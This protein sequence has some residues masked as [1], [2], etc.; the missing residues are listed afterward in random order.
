MS[1]Y[2]K[3]VTFKTHSQESKILPNTDIF[4]AHY[5]HKVKCGINDNNHCNEARDTKLILIMRL[6]IRK[7]N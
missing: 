4:V 7:K 2:A 1:S 5:L 6:T 3:E